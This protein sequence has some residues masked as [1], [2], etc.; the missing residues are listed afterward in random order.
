MAKGKKD[1][2]MEMEPVAIKQE[3]AETPKK[4][5]RVIANMYDGVREYKVGEIIE[6][7]TE[8]MIN[9]ALVIEV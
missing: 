9:R 5:H 8:E 1:E 3:T 4:K 7:A 2:N 6:N